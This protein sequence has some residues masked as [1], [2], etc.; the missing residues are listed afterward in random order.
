MRCIL[1]SNRYTKR[2][3]QLIP[4]P[5]FSE[6]TY[7][8]CS[9]APVPLFVHFVGGLATKSTTLAE[10]TEGLRICGFRVGDGGGYD[11]G[12]HLTEL[13]LFRVFVFLSCISCDDLYYPKNPAS[14]E[15]MEPAI[16]FP[17]WKQPNTALIRF[18]ETRTGYPRRIFRKYLFRRVPRSPDT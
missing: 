12:K 17:N 2:N 15:Q 7:L 9:S 11:R 13:F 18:R 3:I 6:L 4:T 8:S 1:K 10:Q 16:P 14:F 5:F